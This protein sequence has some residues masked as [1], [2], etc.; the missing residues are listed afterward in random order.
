MQEEA[1]KIGTEIQ[2]QQRKDR[3]RREERQD[4]EKR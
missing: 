4:I 1:D 2:H 3:K